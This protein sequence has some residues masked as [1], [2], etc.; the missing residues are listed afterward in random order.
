MARTNFSNWKG[1][2]VLLVLITER[3]GGV[4]EDMGVGGIVDNVVDSV[5][6]VDAG[7]DADDG[8]DVVVIVGVVVV[9]ADVDSVDV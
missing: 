9:V 8:V 4:A 7:M 2:G 5:V 3:D 1:G 6:D